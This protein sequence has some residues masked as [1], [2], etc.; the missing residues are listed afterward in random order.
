MKSKSTQNSPVKS[1]SSKKTTKHL[2]KSTKRPKKGDVGPNKKLSKFLLGSVIF[3]IF[4]SVSTAA[5]VKMYNKTRP[6]R[7][8][9][10]GLYPEDHE[11]AGEPIHQ[12]ILLR[13]KLYA[14]RYNLNN[15]NG[16]KY[17]NHFDEAYDI[18][19]KD[20]RILKLYN[21]ITK[22]FDK[23]HN[24]PASR[25]KTWKYYTDLSEYIFDLQNN[26]EYPFL[27][28]TFKDFHGV[29]NLNSY[30]AHNS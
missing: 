7:A 10:P 28:Q 3:A 18:D 14:Y 30:K 2:D 23:E 8:P 1:K 13:E 9:I 20:P 12:E 17:I 29:G 25:P 4:I 26:P 5:L 15:K 27:L 6:L 19:S 16:Y 24:W 11:L 22:I 21:D